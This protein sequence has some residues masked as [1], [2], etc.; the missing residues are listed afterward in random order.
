M[1]EAIIKSR[2]M[3]QVSDTGAIERIVDEVL[4]ANPQALEDWKKGKTNVAGWLCGQ[5]MK[6]SKGQA[7]PATAT[8]LVQKRLA[9]IK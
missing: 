1:P 7:N 8:A 4:A 9:D 6:L 5:V 3:T 2:G